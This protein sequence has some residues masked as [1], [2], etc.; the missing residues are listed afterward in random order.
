MAATTGHSAL[1]ERVITRAIIERYTEKLLSSL[2]VEV[3]VCG[4]G[5]SGLVAAY[6]LAEAGT[7]VAVFERKLSVGGGM[8][9]G[10]MMFNEIVVQEEAKVILDELDIS[11]RPYQNGYYTVDALE[12][13]TGISYRAI[14]A[15]AKIFNLVS[16]E[17]VLL[18]EDRVCGVVIN[19]S[20]V[21]LANLHV[22]PLAVRARCVIEATGH[23]LEVVGV[24][25]KKMGAC[26][27]TPS[28]RIEGEK[29]MWAEVA[30]TT[31]VANTKQI[32]PG[33]YVTGMSANAAFGSYRMGPIFGGMLLSGK[34]VAELVLTDLTAQGSEAQPGPENDAGFRDACGVPSGRVASPTDSGS[35]G[36]L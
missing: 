20:A 12:A 1:D 23:P 33:L 6:Y 17:D 36:S 10:G 29:P 27:L 28:G 13:V 3:A 19:W 30:E 24:L 4:A 9:G 11:T 16:V 26:L 21:E 8:W 2:D 14:R 31:T 34:K 18:R 35:K 15:G 7:R 22:D 25:E 5:P 32:F